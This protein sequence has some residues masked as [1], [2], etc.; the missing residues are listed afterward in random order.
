MIVLCVC[1]S[2]LRGGGG[3]LISAD[4][5]IGP[6]DVVSLCCCY[7]Q[8]LLIKILSSVAAYRSTVAVVV[9][10]PLI[11]NND[12]SIDCRIDQSIRSL[13]LISSLL[14]VSK[15]K[16][17]R[18]RCSSIDRPSGSIADAFADAD[19]PAPTVAADCSTAVVA[20]INS[21]L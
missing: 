14:S 4:Q 9:L 7:N 15:A 21:E 13:L 19:A 6:I 2:L 20:A 10:L 16:N 11:R 1:D 5:L 8:R 17:S 3:G 12:E 18:F